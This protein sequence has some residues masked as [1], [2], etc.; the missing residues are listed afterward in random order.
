[1]D[2]TS[3]IYIFFRTNFALKFESLLK[4]SNKQANKQNQTNPGKNNNQTHGL[5]MP[6]KIATSIFIPKMGKSS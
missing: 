1:M 2:L 6:E 5:Q 3:E 4:Y